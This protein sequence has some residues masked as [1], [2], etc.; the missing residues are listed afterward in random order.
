MP[1]IATFFAMYSARKLRERIGQ[2]FHER[3]M[4]AHEDREKRRCAVKVCQRNRPPIHVH[5][6]KIGAFVPSGNI[7]LGVR[8]IVVSSTLTIDSSEC[9]NRAEPRQSSPCQYS[10]CA[11]PRQWL[12]RR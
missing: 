1:T 8:A 12:R 7:V 6:R 5:E 3:A 9:P 2:M 11:P 10:E 4:V